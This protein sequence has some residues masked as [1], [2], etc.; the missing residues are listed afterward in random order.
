MC[1]ADAT[2]TIKRSEYGM[3]DGLNVGNPSDEIRLL[4]PVEGYKE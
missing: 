2:G 4:I 3:T 1:A